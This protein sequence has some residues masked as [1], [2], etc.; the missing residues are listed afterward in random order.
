MKLENTKY[1]LITEVF[2]WGLVTTKVVLHF[3]ELISDQ[4]LDSNKFDVKV[5]KSHITMDSAP[6]FE[7]RPIEYDRE[8]VSAYISDE[9]GNRVTGNSK[10]ITLELKYTP[11]M[12]EA[13]PLAFNILLMK[14]EFSE[15]EYKVS[16]KPDK[17]LKSHDGGKIL[18][19]QTNKTC[20]TAHIKLVV[21]DFVHNNDFEYNSIKLKYA[22]YKPD[23]L[24]KK[25][26]IVW[27][28]GMGEGGTDTE[29]LFANK[30][31]N[32]A[33]NEIQ[34]LFG[35]SGAYVLAPQTNTFWMD[36][37]GSSK[38]NV[39]VPDSDGES[40]YT[41]ALFELINHFVNNNSDIDT[42]KIYVGGCS[43]GGYM[44]VKLLVDYPNYFAAAFPICAA[45]AVK[46]LNDERIA[47]LKLAP[48]WFTQSKDDVVVS[49]CKTEGQGFTGK[50]IYDE[51]GD[52]IPV[53]EYTNG[54]FNRIKDSGNKYYSLY[55]SVTDD[56]GLYLDDNNNPYKYNG[57]FSWVYAL[58][59]DCVKVIDG[60]ETTLFEWLGKQ[61]LS[62]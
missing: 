1:T 15:M 51:N 28:H 44:T 30:I 13:S 46:W 57:H 36:V 25:P 2:D 4:E 31:S 34:K 17:Y 59:N 40:F 6:N 3:G 37:D 29:V 43:N 54:I 35:E 42:S 50:I 21:D 62:K 11:T 47:N 10:N 7:I 12:E 5:I 49:V 45:Y 53:D 33:T 23:N 38:M 18:F 20:E 55:D 16:L 19:L 60:K 24:H 8:V 58:K 9:K 48:I 14:N 32:L 22:Y 52:F 56:S 61:N 26:V 41:K 27:L 39:D